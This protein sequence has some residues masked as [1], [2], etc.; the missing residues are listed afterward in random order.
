MKVAP[1]WAGAG[2]RGRLRAGGVTHLNHA[3]VRG[4]LDPEMLQ[5]R[6]TLA[7][8]AN[9]HAKSWSNV[10]ST[11][12]EVL[13]L[14]TTFQV[15]P[16]DGMAVLQGSVAK[17]G[18]ERTKA[19]QHTNYFVMLDDD[20][21]APIAETVAEIERQGLRAVVYT[22][23][24][25]G[26]PVTEVNRD[27]L[28]TWMRAHGRDGEPTAKDAGDFLHAKKN[29]RLDVFADAVLD[30]P[31]HGE[32]GMYQL[33]RHKPM[34]RKRIVLLLEKPFVFGQRGGL[35]KEA[36]VEWAERYAGAAQQ[37]GVAYDHSCVDPSRL[38]YTPRIASNAKIGDGPFDHQ[39]VVIWGNKSLDLDA[40]ERVSTKPKRE[41][42]QRA[43]SSTRGDT[44]DGRFSEIKDFSPSWQIVG[45]DWDAPQW[46]TDIEPDQENWCPWHGIHSRE[47]GKEDTGFKIWGPDENENGWNCQCSHGCGKDPERGA[48]EDGKQ[49]R[50]KFL[51][52]KALDAGVTDA[53]EFAP[54]ITNPDAEAKWKAYREK[55][56][57]KAAKL[58][59][60]D[61][62]ETLGKNETRMLA[63]VGRLNK[64][65]DAAKHL[66]KYAELKVV[67][68]VI[69]KRKGKKVKTCA[70]LRRR[71]TSSRW[72]RSA[73]SVTRRSLR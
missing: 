53:D 55:A 7:I 45:G 17:D 69:Q 18:G 33:L 46:W 4:T 70:R 71:P 2:Q 31:Q 37:I 12:K 23:H 9:R 51:Y 39:I 49:D 65:L 56:Q 57:K 13:D 21:G 58:E 30:P 10:T 59:A 62:A 38:L 6:F 32:K 44:H 14:F 11:G 20:T 26:K 34:A 67:T 52:A 50:A 42:A 63:L 73:S 47:P 1:R 41:K 66:E 54:Y 5:Q 19:N 40:V 35:H 43:S 60:W 72:R 25:H 64:P 29:T 27:Q 3:T 8:G 48:R 61:E 22:T 16:K 15:G 28:I 24:S 68:E 36:M